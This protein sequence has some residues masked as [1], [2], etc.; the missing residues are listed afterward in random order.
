MT[1][2]QDARPAYSRDG[3][4]YAFRRETL[5]RF[6]AIYGADCR[7]LVIPRRESLSI[8]TPDDWS[9]GRTTCWHATSPSERPSPAS[10]RGRS[11]AASASSWPR[12]RPSAWSAIWRGLV[13]QRETIVAGPWLGEV[14]F[15]LLYWVPFLRWFARAVPAAAGAPAGGVARRHG[16][17]VS[18]VCRRLPRDL[19]P[20]DARG[21]P[22]AARRA[23]GRQRRAEADAG[24]G[25]RA[26]AA[27]PADRGHRA[28]HDAAPVEHVPV[29]Q[30]VLVGPPGRGLGAPAAPAT[31]GSTRRRAWASR[32]RPRPTPR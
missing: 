11:A 31:H 27:A 20:R 6:G 23:R 32:S 16:L 30:P 4:V 2:R 9:R 1:R 18:P 21:V 5:D 15:E 12:C 25:I 14:G 8:D 13:A 24:A 3:T 19:R 29:V 7:P 10:C 17:V 26:P 22:R 28:P